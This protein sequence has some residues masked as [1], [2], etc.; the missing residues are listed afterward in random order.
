MGIITND[1]LKFYCS[2]EQVLTGRI[3]KI[4]KKL[5]NGSFTLEKENLYLLKNIPP[6]NPHIWLL[7]QLI[8]KY[9]TFNVGEFKSVG[10]SHNA[11]M[12][13][14]LFNDSI[15][16]YLVNCFDYENQK[17][18]HTPYFSCVENTENIQLEKFTIIELLNKQ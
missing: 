8:A 16:L 17:Y 2:K 5:I 18:E 1:N 9:G 11:V 12:A 14:N 15:D 6:K 13:T 4:V 7:S 3:N 10:W